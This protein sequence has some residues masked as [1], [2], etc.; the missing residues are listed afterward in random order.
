MPHSIRIGTQP[1][2]ETCWDARGLGGAFCS[3]RSGTLWRGQV[4]QCMFRPG[5]ERGPGS[6]AVFHKSECGMVCL[7]FARH[8]RARLVSVGH[9]KVPA[10]GKRV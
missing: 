7:G 8:G 10:P 5:K 6:P 2:L 1:S 4:W 9:G 3:I